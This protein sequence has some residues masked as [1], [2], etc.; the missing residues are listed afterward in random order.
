M[1]RRAL[2]LAAFLLVVLPSVA[3]AQRRPSATLGLASQTAFVRGTD[4]FRMRLDLDRV[5]GPDQLEL[6][7]TVH[8]AVTSRSQFA[9]TIDGDLLGPSVHRD[10]IPFH[11][12]RFDAGGAVPVDVD[13]PSLRE[14][15]YPVAVELVDTAD[16][17]VVA[18]FVTHLIRVPTEPVETPLSVAWVQQYGADPALHPDGTTAIDA[19]QLDGLRVIAAQLGTGVPMTIVPTPETIAALAALDDGAAIKALRELL[20]DHQV[21]STPF[22]DV[23]VNALVGARRSDELARQRAI[24]DATLHDE[25][26]I[27]GDTR[28]WSLAGKVTRQAL[29]ALADLGVQRVV[30]DDDAVAPLPASATA[31]LTLARPFAVPADGT[32]PLDAVSVDPALVAHLDERDDVLAAHHLLADLAVLHFDSPGT[33][34][35]VVIRPPVGATPTAEL[36]TTVFD[37]LGRASILRPVTVDALF[38]RVEP[39]TDAAGERVVRPLA[40]ASAPS[41]GVSTGQ[42]DRA[43]SLITGYGSLTETSNPELPLLERLVLVAE[44]ADLRA[45]AR[46]AYLGAVDAHI[47]GPVSKV[48]VLGDRTYRLTAREGT[49]PLSIVNDNPFDVT[50][51]LD[52]TSDKLVFARSADLG[53]QRIERLLLPAGRTTTEAVP[54]RARTSGAFPLRVVVRSPDGRLE[55]GSTQITI[56]STVASGVGIILSVGAALFLVLWWASHWRSGR[57]T[58]REAAPD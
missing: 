58:R 46:R 14:G 22:V 6:R 52:L 8:R 43:R 7:V 25:L 44:S 54:V 4:T 38:D 40:P 32:G 35:G 10:R 16:H 13:I 18:S 30:L 28:T 27:E 51:T 21:L 9:Q 45:S 15:V 57:R 23:D 47:A 42:L 11:E 1:I 49:I 2:L 55:L 31:G 39:L 24:G 20:A 48:R 19:D 5:H 53:R 29:A 26:G 36:L 12:L 33:P 41:L 17:T 56:T 37:G 3:H 50:V 34:R